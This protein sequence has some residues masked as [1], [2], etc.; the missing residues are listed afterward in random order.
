MR[1]FNKQVGA[2]I[3]SWMIVGAMVV[4]LFVCGLQLLPLYME[5]YAVKSALNSI[6]NDEEIKS[7][8]LLNNK[9]RLVLKG[10]DSRFMVNNIENASVK[11]NV[12][13][14]ET[15]DGLLIVV[16]YEARTHLIFN[17]DGIISFRNERVIPK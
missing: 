5:N 9:K 16:E 11:N 13:T 2:S 7:T 12:H 6:A 3:W 17:I 8:D 10:L 1:L 15:D 14:E 4:T